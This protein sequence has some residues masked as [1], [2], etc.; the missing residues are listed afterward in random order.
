MIN[1]PSSLL[2]EV[3]LWGALDFFGIFAP[4][5]LRA[6]GAGLGAGGGAVPLGAVPRECDVGGVHGK[7]GLE[8]MLP[9][10]GEEGLV[11]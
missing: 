1:L 11:L 6:F 5:S 3:L 8:S 7:L 4:I 9:V 10:P 2:R